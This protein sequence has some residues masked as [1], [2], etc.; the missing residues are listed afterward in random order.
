VLIQGLLLF[1]RNRP[2]MPMIAAP[3]SEAGEVE[4]QTSQ[5]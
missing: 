5:A 2:D 4:R 3:F 1:E